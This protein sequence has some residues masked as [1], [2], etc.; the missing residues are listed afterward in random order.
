MVILYSHNVYFPAFGNV[1]AAI[2]FF[3]RNF[4]YAVAINFSF[5]FNL[6]VQAVFIVFYA[7]RGNRIIAVF[8][9]DKKFRYFFAVFAF[10][11]LLIESKS[12]IEKSKYGI[13]VL[14]D[15]VY[16]ERL[17]AFNIAFS[18]PRLDAG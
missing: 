17:S 15:V 14:P 11:V 16:G 2:F 6:Y 13:I 18:V 4:S 3:K 9:F 7:M 8:V 10:L 5:Y 12:F 1:I